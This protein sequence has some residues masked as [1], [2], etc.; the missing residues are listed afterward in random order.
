MIKINPNIYIATIVVLIIIVLWFSY[1]NYNVHIDKYE[2]YMYGYWVADQKFCE[3]SGI[4]SMMLFIGDVCSADEKQAKFAIMNESTADFKAADSKSERNIKKTSRAAY[5]VI[6][7]DITN[8]SLLLNYN[9]AS[10]G[11]GSNLSDYKLLMS[12]DYEEEC[13]IPGKVNFE[14]NIEKNRLRIYWKNKMYGVF[15][16]DS[17]ITKMFDLEEKASCKAKPAK[18]TKK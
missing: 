18:P 3:D 6:N 8:Q 11:F 14:F 5:L 15:Y 16:K 7:N 12:V 13:T 1:N 4:S 2:K 17:E 10:S 9:R